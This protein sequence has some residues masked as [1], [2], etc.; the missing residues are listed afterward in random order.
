MGLRSYDGVAKPG[1]LFA[2][3]KE[4]QAQ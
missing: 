4:L 3:W 1:G 2:R